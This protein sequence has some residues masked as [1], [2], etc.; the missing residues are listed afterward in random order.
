MLR[1][2]GDPSKI[3]IK[4]SALS[5]RKRMEDVRIRI[6]STHDGELDDQSRQ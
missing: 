6:K 3:R 2:L 4:S 1:M 5:A